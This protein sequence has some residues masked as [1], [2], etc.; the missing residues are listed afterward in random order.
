MGDAMRLAA[1]KMSAL[2]VI[3]DLRDRGRL[4]SARRCDLI[5]PSPEPARRWSAGLV[6]WERL[7]LSEPPSREHPVDVAVPSAR[8]RIQAGFA[9]CT[10]YD[11]AL[12][13]GAYLDAG[14]G[15]LV[16][17][18]ELLFL[19]MASVMSAP[20]HVL[21]GFE[22]CGRFARDAFDPRTGSVRMGVQPATSVAQ[23]SAFLGKCRWSRGLDRARTRLKF[24]ADNAW[25]PM[26]AVVATLASLPEYELGYDLG[27]VVLNH[28]VD[29]P[30]QLVALG[31]KGSRVPDVLISGTSVGL[32]YDGRGHF[33]ELEPS[34]AREKYVDDL[35]RNRELAAMGLTV[36]PVTAEDL[37]AEN[38]LDIVM[39][40]VAAAVAREDP[41]RA[42]HTQ[43]II[44]AKA[45]RGRRQELVWSLLPWDAAASY[46]LILSERERQAISQS[47]VEDAII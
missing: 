38:G 21:L 30:G 33:D 11:R 27:P 40:E 29:N 4:T 2:H 14:E 35:R 18:P 3:R 15:L 17:C 13:E 44:S 20:V 1:S 9:R 47:Y 23:I 37:F 16:P 42:A 8:A 10:I 28:R 6:P 41:E 45:L 12:P 7:G 5:V 43:A 32:N 25:S 19:E 22:L 36:L 46:S 34:A 26:E 31:C 24:V 39:L